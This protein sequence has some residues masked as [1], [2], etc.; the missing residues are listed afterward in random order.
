MH[1]LQD[2][3]DAPHVRVDLRVRQELRGQV[4]VELHLPN[5]I[6]VA[7]IDLE[8]GKSLVADLHDRRGVYPEGGVEEAVVEQLLEQ[9]VR[10]VRGAGH[11]VLGQLQESLRKRKTVF[12]MGA[13]L[14]QPIITG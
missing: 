9:E 12:I 5:E 13:G 14:T 10:V 11:Q 1:R 6:G 8:D 2:G 4:R 7:I 3:G